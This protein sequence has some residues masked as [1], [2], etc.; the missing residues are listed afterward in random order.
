V[1][2]VALTKNDA[3]FEEVA[4]NPNRTDRSASRKYLYME[5]M[6]SDGQRQ[7]AHFINELKPSLGA[8]F[9]GLVRLTGDHQRPASDR[10]LSYSA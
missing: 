9:R 6:S 5:R 2:I 8:S 7:V 10:G 4:L 1:V 3:D